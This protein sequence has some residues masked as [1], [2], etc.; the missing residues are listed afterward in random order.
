[1]LNC[2]RVSFWA[3]WASAQ[4]DLVQHGF[5]SMAP[6]LEFD[7]GSARGCRGGPIGVFLT[8]QKKHQKDAEKV[9]RITVVWLDFKNVG[10]FFTGYHT[11]HTYSWHVDPYT[12][13]CGCFDVSELHS[14]VQL[15]EY[16]TSP[17]G[18][19]NFDDTQEWMPQLVQQKTVIRSLSDLQSICKAKLS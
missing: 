7:E 6:A 2:Q 4:C 11:C 10:I 16:Q 15:Q 18:L 12:H 13:L 17:E 8:N 3:P 14:P 1:M 5:P 19:G 9:Q